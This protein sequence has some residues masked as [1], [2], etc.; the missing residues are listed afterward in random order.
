M[1]SC[2]LLFPLQLQTT[3]LSNMKF[4]S[5]KPSAKKSEGVEEVPCLVY[6]VVHTLL[7]HFLKY[8]SIDK[9]LVKLLSVA[10]LPPQDKSKCNIVNK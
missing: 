1:I 2:R 3:N 10:R 9:I 6:G 4:V 8:T 7:I 5:H